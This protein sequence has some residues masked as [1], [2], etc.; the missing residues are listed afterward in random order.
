MTIRIGVDTGGTFTDVVLYDDETG[1]IHTTKTPSTPSEF[2]QGVLNGIDKILEM[3]NTDAARASYL[4]H[5]TTVGTNAVLESEIPDLGLITNS[6]L[7]DVL[8]IGDQTRPEL[9]NLQAEKPPALIP[10]KHRFG[11]GGR[12]DA[13]GDIIDELDEEAVRDAVTNLEDA[14]VDSI[15]VS[16]LFS[17]LNSEHEDRIGDIIETET[18][19]DYALSSS[20]YPETREYD[21]TVTT[22]LNEAVKI[23]IKDYLERLDSGIEKRGI[24]VPLNV[25]HS[26]G[27][28]F[29]TE[30]ATD[31][32]LR[33]VLSGPAA[34]AVA[35]RD[36][37]TTEDFSHAIG[38]DMGGTSA[39]VSIVE[40]GSIIRSTEGEINNLPINTPL[41]DI[42]TVGAG[43]GSIA[44]IDNGGGLR[45]GPKSSG[46]DPGPICYGRGGTEPTITDANLILG[47]IDPD[48]FLKGDVQSAIERSHDIFKEKIV[49]PLGLSPEEAAMDI[50]RVA[51]AKMAREIRRVTIERGRDPAEYTLVPFGGAGPLQAPSVA[52]NMDMNSLLLPRTPGVLS[53]RGLLLADVR[54]DESQAYT[55]SDID[56]E[57]VKEEFNSLETELLSRFAEQGFNNAEVELNYQLDLRYSGQAYELT[58]SLPGES[59][60]KDHLESGIDRFHELHQELYGYAMPDEPIELITLRLAGTVPTE[61]ITDEPTIE[62]RESIKSSRNVYFEEQGFVETPIVDRAALAIGE[63]L[64]GP[65]II[66]ESGCTSIVLPETT[67]TV[68]EH[69]NLLIQ[70]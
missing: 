30:Q 19:L 67:A 24:D 69:G 60:S 40:D 35:C 21:R 4:S 63:K 59:F 12:L 70:L 64:E 50:L 37:S 31:F 62:D 38:L 46:A 66:E 68:S 7:R 27:G 43:G 13:N 8:E 41:V 51:N 18:D 22:V 17:Y 1:E 26:G 25:M 54:M 11:V 9:Y 10:R 3:T 2:D 53:A 58:V 45:V 44:W 42:H 28:I 55:G 48:I 34:G 56:A 52:Q 15:V 65:A 49:E 61:R 29:G 14:G 6:G 32:A 47:R 16:M 39:D 33:T 20:V 36:V 23:T 57:R 5:G